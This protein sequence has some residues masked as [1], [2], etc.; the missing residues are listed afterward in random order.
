[1]TFAVITGT[2]PEI[3]K[4]FPLMRLFD[5]R[6]IDYKFI[7]TGQHHDYEMFLKFIKDFKIREPDYS[8]KLE[9]PGTA[10]VAVVAG[11]GEGAG[12]TAATRGGPVQQFAE[13]M[14]KT[15][16]ILRQI[17]P[18]SV[19]VVGDTNSVAASA[20]TATQLKIPTIHLEAGLRSYDWRMPEEYNRRMV[21]HISDVLFSPTT[22]SA[23]NLAHEQVHGTVHVV[24]NTVIDAVRICMQLETKITTKDYYIDDDNNF[25]LMDNNY[26]SSSLS[27]LSDFVLL[28]LHRQENVDNR[29]Y[30]KSILTALSASR[31][32]CI[33]PMHPRTIKRIHEF[34][35]ENLIPSKVIAPVGYFEFLRLLKM[36]KFVIT[37]SGG[38]QEEITSPYINKHALVLRN[39]TE[40]PESILSG[41]AML[42]KVDYHDILESIKRISVLEPPK[43]ICPFGDGNSANKII[44]ILE[45]Q[46][47]VPLRSKAYR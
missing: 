2:R 40:R 43:N 21:D 28:T 42:C 46:P 4:M 33:C 6:N 24:G 34:G 19:L 15:G 11:E 41:H 31:L 25:N 37:D 47:V 38:V 10:A 23:S 32:N 22:I 7:H 20:L 1:M 36:C 39:S 16:D 13:V 26:H 3:I 5:L 30:L 18:S 35:L 44:E 8:I 45:E 14:T 27:S 17:K 9:N 29:D 12:G